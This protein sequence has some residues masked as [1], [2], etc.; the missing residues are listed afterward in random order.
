MEFDRSHILME[1][2]N[3]TIVDIYKVCIEETGYDMGVTENFIEYHNY[4]INTPL[5]INGNSGGNILLDGGEGIPYN[6]M[7]M[8]WQT[9]FGSM[10]NIDGVAIPESVRRNQKIG[11]CPQEFISEVSKASKITGIP[12]NFYIAF[13]ALESGWRNCAP[14]SSGYGGYFGQKPSQGGSGSIFNQAQGIMVSIYKNALG[15]AKK[16]GFNGADLAVWCYL[17]HN[18]GNAGARTMLNALGGKLRHPDIHAYET[19]ARAFVNKYGKKWSAGTQAAQIK[20]KTLSIP[21]AYYIISQI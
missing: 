11:K 9:N 13:G 4:L 21:K 16:Y 18:A 20:E 3:R 5:S 15:D 10:T 14:N 17:C 8:P 2:L 7:S 19:A 12:V 1:E 6:N